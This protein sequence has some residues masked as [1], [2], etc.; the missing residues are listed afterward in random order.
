M[1]DMPNNVD[2]VVSIDASAIGSNGAALTAR[3]QAA[4]A[5]AAQY[6]CTK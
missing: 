3:Y 4:A 1:L 6:F 2:I 5:V